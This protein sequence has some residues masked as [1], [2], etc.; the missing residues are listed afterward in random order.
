MW[1]TRLYRRVLSGRQGDSDV[2]CQGDL[3]C[4]VD[5]VIVTCFCGRH[6]Y[7]DV[8]CQGDKVI[9]TCFVRETLSVWETW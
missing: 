8:F 4:V 7:I 5:M 1:E 9:V 2:L 3:I 6:G